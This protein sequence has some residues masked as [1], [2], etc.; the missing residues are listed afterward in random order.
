MGIHEPPV[1]PDQ[2]VQAFNDMSRKLAGLTAAIDG[3]AARQQELHARDYGPDLEKIRDGYEKVC[4]A[5]NILAKRPAMTLTP[6]E[7]AKQIEAAGAQGRADDHRAWSG[8]SQTLSG[9]VRELKG[10]VASAHAAET[11][12]LWIAGAAA[13]ALLVG[14]A[15]GTAVPTV[16]A[17]LA[18]ESWHWPE[19]R[20]AALLRRTPWDAGVRLMQ[21][22]NPPEARALAEAARLSKDNADV[23]Q[24][25]RKRAEQLSG[26]VNCS[27]KISNARL[28]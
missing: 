14:F 4:G 16:I 27:I 12:R 25:C 24:G 5:I 11:Q 17:Q 28:D 13:L 3:F 9:T 10:I 6:Q 20:A 19:A 1:E 2:T 26:T 22:A 18:P 23:L 8:A 21:V 7:V 15:S